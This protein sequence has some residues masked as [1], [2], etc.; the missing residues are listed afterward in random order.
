M[1]TI[2]TSCVRHSIASALLLTTLSGLL[3]G[4]AFGAPDTSTTRRTEPTVDA[5][6]AKQH[7]IEAVDDA[8]A[9]L[10]G[11][12]KPRTGPDYA[13]DCVLPDGEQGARWRYLTG[14]ELAG[15]PTADGA[16]MA[17][18]WR[19]QGMEVVVRDSEDGPAVFGSGGDD[20]AGI[21]VYAY[22]GN[23]TVQALSRCFPGDADG[24]ME[25]LSDE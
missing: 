20:I 4:C 13:E 12:W 18:H 22:S 24:I 19:A 14:S 25:Q 1:I 9:R 8:T 2:S 3:A 7:M 15:D 11:V 17:D 5:D 6:S 16:R 23:Y 21:S 10:G